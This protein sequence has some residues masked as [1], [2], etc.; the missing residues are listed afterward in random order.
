MSELDAETIAV[1][2]AGASESRSRPSVLRG[3]R[4]PEFLRDEILAEIFAATVEA[5]PQAIAMTTMER[6]IS[7]ARVDH[8]ATALAR[9]L[10]R[11]G[12]GPGDVV[13][14]W[15]ARGPELL[16]SQ[17]AIAKTGAAW[18]PFD[19]DAPVER[20][21]TCL[22]DA[23]AKGLLTSETF[24][25]KTKGGISVAVLTEANLIDPSDQTPVDARKN[26]AT[27]DHPAYMIYTSGSTGT[28]KGIVITGRNICH[29]LRSANESYRITPDDVVFQGASIAFDLSMEEIWIP[30]LVGAELFVATPAVLGEAEKLPELMEEIGVTVLDTVPTLLSLL[31]R[32]IPSLRVIIL[33]GEA[34]PPAVAARWCKPGRTIFNSYGPTEATVVATMAEV[35]PDKPV[36]IGGPIANYTCYVADEANNLLPRGVEGELLIGGPGVARGYLKRDSLTAEKFI[37]NPFEA[38]GDDP[39][40]YRS[41][42]AVVM[43][44]DG[45]ISFHGRIDD[46]VKIRGFRVELG[47]IESKLSVQ[48]GV[49]QAAVVLRNDDGMDQLV[50]FLVPEPGATLDHKILRT[51][52]RATLPPYMTPARYETREALPRLSSGKVDRKALKKET[53]T[54]PLTADEAQEEP[55]TETEAILLDAAKKVLPPQSVPFEADFFTD[56]GGHSLLAARFVSIVRQTP[57]LAGVT[58]QDMY[59]GRTLRAIAALLD[60]KATV[61]GGPKDLSFEPPPFARRF[62]CGLAQAIALPFILALSTAQWLGIFVSYM[63]LTDT[64]ASFLQEM[65]SLLG[66]YLI[67]QILTVFIAIAVKWIVIGRF[68]PG[69]YPLWGV[70]YFRWWLVV[71]VLMLTHIKWFQGSPLMRVYLQALGVK[72]GADANISELEIGALDLVSIGAGTTI[73]QRV[74]L[75][76][77]SFVGN[78]MIVGPIDIGPDCYIGT[79]CVIE[80]H[81]V[82]EEG[83]ELRDLT[84]IAPHTRIGAWEI[85][86][87]SPGK[88]VGSVDKESLRP[89]A[90]VSAGK[91]SLQTFLYTLLLLSIPPVGLLPLFPAFWVFDRIDEFLGLAA[92]SRQLYMAAIPIMAWPTSFVMVLVTVGFIAAV[93]WIVLPRVREG[94]Y[95]VFSWFYMRKWAV[96]LATE[97]TLETL[98]SLYATIY[99]R[100]WYRLMGAK[101]GKDS[102]ISTNL[103]GRYDLVEIGDKCFIADEVVLGDEDVRRGWMHLEALKT[104]SRVFVGNDGVV[105]PGAVIPDDALIGIKSKP[106]AND[107]MSAGDTWFG[108]P[109]IKLP[110]RQRFDGGGANWTYEA[111]KWRKFARG[112]FEAVHIS[113][114]TMLF[115]T[116][117]TWAIEWF[118]PALLEGH[119]GQVAWMF[120]VVSVLIGLA[121]TA[122]VIAV[123][124]LTMGRYE[125]V[126][127][128]MW[129]W[130]AMR[131]EAVAV[132]Y[133]GL[134]GKALLE[135]LRGTPFLPWVM[136]LFGAKIGKGCLFE[137]TDITEF[138]CVEVGDFCTLNSLCALQTHLY[139]DRVMK[140]GRVKLGSGVTVGAGSTVLYDSHVGDFARLGPLTI[141]MK[142]ESI[143]AHTE[144]EGSP[145]VPAKPKAA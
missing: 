130:W 120:V 92:T 28:P 138:D 38:T 81:C 110:V 59:A 66:V 121:M 105:P 108:S 3:A 25:A 95:S 75:S 1:S 63:L 126:T 26:G 14:L 7:Y 16:I 102:E 128:P 24:A 31:P 127:K 55:Q 21:D 10:V 73:G 87:G 15:G 19:A 80:E 22:R 89:F 42:D 96:A 122:V 142:G 46:Q 109:P 76:N 13:G 79:S 86:D 67:V 54:A 43:E 47:E 65:A 85:W 132:L 100:A 82:L 12:I 64:D 136:R 20:I 104:G 125:P 144:W 72:V 48:P 50:A 98:S 45:S 116:F 113:L 33:G 2:E 27:P 129:S 139:E 52:L 101:I 103:A 111:P 84:A 134:A 124:W 94:Y 32:D 4:R 115:I 123:K 71:R 141:V 44:A 58:L 74:N 77:V 40:L 78:E 17:I 117:G 70:Y 118:G 8:E 119:Y 6:K 140:V 5:A 11:R 131:T 143:P 91:R 57:H 145:A 18:L 23:E 53:L 90:T 34:C 99:M 51:N 61:S 29:Y 112:V 133:W 36:T 9:G 41:G 68:K 35:H 56:L 88:C 62:F 93:R 37:K 83:A 135:P 137:M 97:V 30:Y 114:P 69:R 107:L 49:K 60:D 39:I 106:P